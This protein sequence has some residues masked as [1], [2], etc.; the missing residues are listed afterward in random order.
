MNI[1]YSF[2]YDMLKR[3]MV[4]E[5]PGTGFPLPFATIDAKSV[6]NE[7]ERPDGFGLFC[8]ADLIAQVALLLIKPEIPELHQPEYR[9]ETRPRSDYSRILYAVLNVGL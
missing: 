9:I 6:R 3:F 7:L 5:R 8:G 2:V 1:G 4:F